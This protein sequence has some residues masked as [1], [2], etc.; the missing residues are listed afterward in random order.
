MATEVYAEAENA[1]RHWEVELAI[2][3]RLL[4]GKPAQLWNGVVG[5]MLWLGF[6]TR[7]QLHGLVLPDDFGP[8]PEFGVRASANGSVARRPKDWGATDGP[9]EATITC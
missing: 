8:G 9:S 2:P 6:L 4:A 1:E 5:E 7:F 3:R